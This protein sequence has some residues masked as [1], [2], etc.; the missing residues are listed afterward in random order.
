M[1]TTLE[2]PD[3]VTDTAAGPGSYEAQRARLDARI[4]EAL[5][6]GGEAK[7]ARRR[8]SGHLNARERIAQLLDDG[9]FSETGML[10]VS[11]LPA[12][13]GTSPADAKITGTGRV[14]G[15]RVAVVSNDMTV[16][17][18]SS[19]AVNMRKIARLKETATRS[20]MPL[21][22]L[23]ESSGS[24]VPDSLGAEA[25]AGAGQDPQQYCRRR[26]IP[27]VSAVLGPC[28]G[29]STWYTCL[30][31]FVVMRKGAFLAVSSARVTSLAIGEAVDPG[32]LGGWK[33]H[34]EQTGLVDVI[35]DSD[36][37]ALAAIRRFLGYLPSHAGV[38]PPSLPAAKATAPDA[39]RLLELV[40]S[41]RSK[42]YDMR[43]VIAG[44]V[45]EGSFFNL[46]DRFG[47][48]AVTGLARLNGESVGIVASNPMFKGGAMDPEACRKV[49]SFLVM[50][51]SFNIPIL[52][53]V[54]TPGF[55]V[56]IEGERKAA[57]AHI[58]NMIHAVQLCSVPKLSV[59]LRKSYGQAYINM[60]GGRNS[61]EVAAWT[62]ADTSFMDPQ[63][64]VSVLHGIKRE[65]DPARFDRLKAE[66]ARDTSAY[67]L[68]GA[69]GVQAVIPPQQTRAWLIEALATHRREG[70][71]GIGQHEMRAWPTYI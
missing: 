66:L 69:F 37:E 25:M 18:A 51:D 28:L 40:P 15:R 54:D 13:R 16:M 5:A 23:G 9:S 48:A 50:C 4:R 41:A 24:R 20:G 49:T 56:G 32:E 26:E 2:L 21:I 71:G 38:R 65:D 35:V 62:S 8:A 39:D 47:R 6:M 36:E 59:I 14:D 44:I 52:F 63:I 22:F 7:L 11:V 45:D 27:W 53:L 3:P 31:D 57:P 58:M 12:D 68:A 30:S 70:N 10:A 64:G 61:D 17:G 33:L 42:T 60:G 1:D 46:K 34:A 43:K 55:L 29:S 19:S 67:A